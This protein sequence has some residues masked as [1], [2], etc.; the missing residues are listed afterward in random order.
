MRPI[1][2]ARPIRPVPNESSV[3]GSGITVGT[4]TATPVP[5]VRLLVIGG[6]LPKRA[7]KVTTPVVELMELARKVA[8]TIALVGPLAI[9]PSMRLSV[10]KTVP[11]GLVTVSVPLLKIHIPLV[12]VPQPA[13]KTE[14]VTVMV[15]R[16]PTKVRL[17]L[18]RVK[19]PDAVLVI[20][21]LIKDPVLK[22]T[23]FAN[24]AVGK[25]RTRSANAICGRLIADT[26]LGRFWPL[27]Q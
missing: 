23:L 10:N 13:L 1:I 27:S 2:P 7:S 6:V 11:P 19:P 21:P 17:K 4:V 18:G 16:L 12:L 8:V 20:V 26:P 3:P 14:V 25:V 5:P 9:D 15:S 24:A 22:S